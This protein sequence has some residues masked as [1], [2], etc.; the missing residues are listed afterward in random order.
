MVTGAE[1]SLMLGDRLKAARG[2]RMTQR[3]LAERAEVSL[4]LIK[5][6]EQGKR[7]STTV[8]TLHRLARALDTTVGQLLGQPTAL[9]SATPGSGVLA[10]RAAL[11]PVA[12]LIAADLRPTEPEPVFGE[13]E[14]TLDAA[15]RA[16][17]YAWGAYWAGRYELLTGLVPTLLAQ[18]RA[19]VRAV[20]AAQRAAAQEAL[21]R[22][23]QVAGD[24]AVHLGQPDLAWLAVREAITAA[25]H[26]DDELLAAALRLSVSWQLLV[27]GSYTDASAVALTAARQITPGGTASIDQVS[28]YGLLTAAA[29]TATARDGDADQAATLLAVSTEMAARVGHERSVAQSVFGPA[30]ITAL[31]VDCAVVAEDYTRGLALGQ[32]IP[33]DA[34]LPVAIRARGLADRALCQTRLG[35]HDAATSTL[36]ALVHLAPDWLPHQRL[37]RQVAAELVAEQRRLSPM[38]REVAD[39]LG[40]LQ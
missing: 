35:Q 2:R 14:L 33:R 17:S 6:L 25:G 38:L 16:V 40:V 37:P 29:A 8:R 19:T 20:P 18:L 32:R 26:G 12:D 28:V 9:P 1:D 30:K 7:A 39:R 31:G 23:L 24:T 21:A 10:L 11:T 3:E 36:R 34:A 15:N 13:D 27:Q 22:G 4:D 5:S